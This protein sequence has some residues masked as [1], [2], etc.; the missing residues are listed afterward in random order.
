[1]INYEK[2]MAELLTQIVNK[3]FYKRRG[4]LDIL[5][6]YIVLLCITMKVIFRN[7][8][9]TYI[10]LY[11]NETK[12]QILTIIKKRKKYWSFY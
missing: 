1:M 7:R 4:K 2:S 12:M 5:Y 9:Y 10:L 3:S 6:I 8:H 11:H